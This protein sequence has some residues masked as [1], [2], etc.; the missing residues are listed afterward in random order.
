MIRHKVLGVILA[1]L[2]AQN[3]AHADGA[4]VSNV[5]CT[6]TGAVNPY[7]PLI[8]PEDY[9]GNGPSKTC[10]MWNI[11]ER[12][13]VTLSCVSTY[14]CVGKYCDQSAQKDEAL[15]YDITQHTY[16]CKRVRAYYREGFWF[17]RYD[18]VWERVCDTHTR[19]SFPGACRQESMPCPT[20]PLPTSVN[21]SFLPDARVSRTSTCDG[22]SME[23]IP[24]DPDLLPSITPIDYPNRDRLLEREQSSSKHTVD[25]LSVFLSENES[26]NARMQSCGG[27]TVNT[28]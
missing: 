28:L 11:G 6:S 17:K 18:Y 2:V 10:N 1:L 25:E 9:T 27:E 15:G 19:K 7:S 13:D 26:I 22:G 23:L 4:A 8:M 3:F 5:R 14:T 16:E 20:C 24:D 21:L 12:A